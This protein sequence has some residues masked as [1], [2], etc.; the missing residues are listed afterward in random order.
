MDKLN[1]IGLP[2]IFVGT[3]IGGSLSSLSSLINSIVAQIWKDVF[4]RFDHFKTASPSY[5]TLVNK[6]LCKY[7]KYSYLT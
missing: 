5:S 6:I 4:L 2:G 1:Y 7:S 3:I